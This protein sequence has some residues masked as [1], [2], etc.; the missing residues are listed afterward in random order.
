[1]AQP[2]TLAPLL[3]DAGIAPVDPASP[4]ADAIVDIYWLITAISIAILLV[5]TVPLLWFV[6]RY[7]AN[8]RP[9]EV[10][11]P[12]VRGNTNLELAWTAVPV[13]ILIVIAAFVF[14]KYP[15]IADPASAGE[16][17]AEVRVEGRQFY[18]QYEYANGV[19]AI[20][21][22]R[23]PA[24]RTTELGITAPNHDVIHSFWVPALSGKRDAVPGTVTSM[25][26]KPERVGRFTVVCGEFCGIQHAFM[27]GA[28]EVLPAEEFDAW[29]EDEAAAQQA[30]TSDLGE[31]TYLGACAKC[32]GE[33]GEGD[34][35]PA[36]AG[37]SLFEQREGIEE[38]IRNGRAKMPAVGKDWS[39]RQMDELIEYLREELGDEG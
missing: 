29:L 32:H 22:L 20:D 8:G 12:Q 5:V 27:R 25:R 11:G 26:V 21:T 36:I 31:Q 37:S 13:L 17:P 3:A 7:R 39:D 14:Y 38:L 18:W 33:E 23:L 34:I 30:G 28:V 2:V 16:D 24:G 19:L 9:R 4:G 1:M 35:G 15:G 6:Y 10:E